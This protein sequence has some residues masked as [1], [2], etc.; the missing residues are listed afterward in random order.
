MKGNWDKEKI[1]KLIM[2]F[3]PNIENIP[4]DK[5]LIELGLNSLQIMRIINQIRKSGA[6][7]NF[8][9]L[10]NAPT[11]QGWNDILEKASRTV[12]KNTAV[13][14]NHMKA[15][16]PKAPLT[17]VQY[18]Y[19]IGRDDNQPMGGV[20]CHAYIEIDGR[21]VDVEQL[22]K[23]WKHL[24]TIHPMLRARFTDDGRQ[25]I[26]ELPYD[27]QLAVYDL[28]E[29]SDTCKEE[30]LLKI[31]GELSH[32]KMKTELGQVAGLAIALLSGENSK[33]YFD[34]DLLICD[35]QSFQIILRDLSTVYVNKE[36][37]P[38]NPLW[39]FT[40]YI[41]TLDTK[42]SIEWM[43]AKKYW[44]NRLDTLPLRPELPLLKYPEDIRYPKYI[45]RSKFCEAEIWKRIKEIAAELAVTP[46]M[47]LLTVYAEVLDYWSSNSEF[48]I[49]IPLFDRNTQIDG[50]EDVV[51][52]FTNLL[53]L[54]V[55][56]KEKHTFID[57]LKSIKNQF[58][59]DM[60]YTAYSGVQVQRDLAS[61]YAG[62]RDFAPIVF[63]CNLGTEL[64]SEEFRE[65][66]G[67]FSFMISQTPQVWI[68]FQ[69]FEIDGQLM[70]AWDSVDEMFPDGLVESMFT[71]YCQRLVDLA[72]DANTRNT[73]FDLLPQGQQEK[74]SLDKLVASSDNVYML[75]QGFLESCERDGDKVALSEAD[76][77]KKL[78]YRQLYDRSMKVAALL[79]EKG[80]K[81]EELVCVM[82]PRG[83]DQI[84]AIYGI[85]FAGAAYVP[86]SVEQPEERIKKIINKVNAKFMIS[87]HDIES[88]IEFWDVDFLDIAEIDTRNPLATVIEV[89]TESTAYVIM[90]S[91]STGEPKGVEVSHAS[92]WN[93]IRDVNARY[94]IDASA[95]LLGIS[96]VDFDLSV[97]DNF[98]I[99]GAGGTLHLLSENTSKDA[100]FWL[101]TILENNITV[102]NSVPILLKMLLIEMDTA[103]SIDVPLQII[104]LSGDWIERELPI[105]LNNKIPNC[106]LYAMGGATEGA[107]WSNYY[108]VDFPIPKEWKN[109]PYGRPLSHQTYRVVDSKGR[110]CPDWVMGELWIGGE[111]VAKG[112]RGDIELTAQKFLYEY[113][114]K[115]Y[116]TG[117]LGRFWPDRT[118]E[119]M[120]RKDFQVKIKGHRIELGEIESVLKEHPEIKDALAVAKTYENGEKYLAAYFVLHNPDK[121]WQEEEIRNFLRGKLASYMVPGSF[122]PMVKIPLTKNGKVD[123]KSL[124][125][126]VIAKKENQL[127]AYEGEVEEKLAN[128][129]KQILAVDFVEREADY[130]ELGG[131]SLVAT[132]MIKL[133]K[134]TF[135]VRV[136]IRDIFDYPA[137]SE[138]AGR[139]EELQ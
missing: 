119:I 39:L 77:G 5:N 48:L 67:D 41:N 21:N 8:P 11:I 60:E 128:I 107:I 69:I 19:W 15:E 59:E 52:D 135:A 46:A 78:T 14:E 64:L 129:W 114:Q 30:E 120:G 88:T 57:L 63:A 24:F 90:T 32:R 4:E 86:I 91:G 33:I 40:K 97:Y 72:K 132:E 27:D 80:V 139:I 126:P 138:L 85:L 117:D 131:N 108:K 122:V 9:Q 81:R 10:I 54:A 124:P 73:Q 42:D 136:P 92:A 1:E 36:K 65:N 34:I 35:V 82:L 18:S 61:L 49:N 2:R 83:A 115:W 6:S 123:R 121:S 76:T 87:N 58:Y 96:G 134:E 7:V 20:G 130:F 100:N 137:L 105:M 102:W 28:R 55:N 74:R 89:N 22:Q 31:R 16:K 12:S 37:P 68:D 3:L 71:I 44:Q 75:Y 125:D 62:E 111:G 38:V 94:R 50:I 118:I 23:A 113:G 26:M 45:R 104:M 53:L 101:K 133:I 79:L 109:I 112:Y 66:L 93:T 29:K 84:S 127:A 47:I 70:L 116:K 106:E 98:G 51:A 99:L 56:C 13:R 95:S 110:D 25:E 103:Q 17:D 43:R